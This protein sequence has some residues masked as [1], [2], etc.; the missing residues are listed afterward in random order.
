MVRYSNSYREKRFLF[1][2]K[3]RDPLLFVCYQGY[4]PGAYSWP[5]IFIQYPGYELS[6]V[7]LEW[8]RIVA[9]QFGGS[10]FGGKKR[11]SRLHIH[12]D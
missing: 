5:I 7:I 9:G 6:E 11:C 3:L 4:L 8:T 10:N 1:S 2:P 12:A